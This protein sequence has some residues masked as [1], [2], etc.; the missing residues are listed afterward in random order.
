[1]GCCLGLEQLL[2]RWSTAPKKVAAEKDLAPSSHQS[3]RRVLQALLPFGTCSEFTPFLEQFPS[4]FSKKISCQERGSIFFLLLL[5]GFFCWQFQSQTSLKGSGICITSHGNW[6][7][8]WH[9]GTESQAWFSISKPPV[10]STLSFPYSWH[11]NRASLM[12]THVHQQQILL[13]WPCRSF[14][15]NMGL[16]IWTSKRHQ[17]NMINFQGSKCIFPLGKK[18]ILSPLK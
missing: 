16:H 14:S 12:H 11:L 10:I 5:G 3:W 4:K 9:H 15:L 2:Q 7:N 1:M 8:V 13:L 6:I 18:A 17:S